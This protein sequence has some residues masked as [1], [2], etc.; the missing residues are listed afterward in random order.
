VC[1]K[2]RD[3]KTPVDSIFRFTVDAD[4]L[5]PG[6]FSRPQA[7]AET[8][9]SLFEPIKPQ[10]VRTVDAESGL[11]WIRTGAD[12]GRLVLM[13]NDEEPDQSDNTNVYIKTSDDGGTT[14]S[15]RVTVTAANKS[16]FLP[17]MAMD[18]ATGHLV[19]GWHDASL[20]DGSGAY[21]TD[22]TGNTDAMYALSFSADAGDTWTAPQMISEGASNAEASGNG[23]EF[24]DYTGLAFTFGV[25][26]PAWA[27]NSDSTGDNPDGTLHAFD[28]YSAAGPET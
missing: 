5:R 8:N 11:A 16:Q 15:K 24:G 17:R 19:V 27:D 3:R 9:V 13:F 1:Q 12:R 2:D 14:W 25:A 6:R 28:I 10:R 22:G 23:I 20:D 18:P 26:H 7:I 21:D 4:G